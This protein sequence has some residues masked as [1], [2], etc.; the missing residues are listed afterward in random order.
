MRIPYVTLALILA[1]NLA[2][3]LY[4][5]RCLRTRCRHKAWSVLQLVTASLLNLGIVSLFFIPVQSASDTSLV[6]LMWTIFGYITI[7][8]PKYVFTVFDLLASLP[9]LWHKRRVA[10]LSMTGG[11]M[12]V[13]LFVVLWWGALINRY[14]ID[15]KEVEVRIPNLPEAFEGMRIVQISDLHVGTYRNDS[16]FLGKLVASINELHPDMIVFTGDI[17]N[18]RTAELEPFVDVLS[19]LHAPYGVFSVLG[20]H[21]YGD[22][23]KWPEKAA[24]EANNNRLAELNGRMGWTLLNNDYRDIVVDGDTL[25]IIGVENIGDPPFHVYGDLSKAYPDVTDSKTKILLSHNPSHWVMNIADHDDKE[26]ALTLSGH[27][28]AMQMTFFGWSPA[29]FRY[30][31]W[32]GLY[33]DQSGKHQLYVNIGTGTVGFPARIGATPEVTLITLDGSGKK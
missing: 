2:G 6:S 33:A 5:W 25:V 26:V 7:Y 12:A 17:V 22:Y 30:K 3:D 31:T 10:A 23:Y 9:R 11:V 29:S 1:L 20:N 14:N 18:R 19:G 13:V 32:G 8:V 24:R 21:D 28:H 4:I 16:T 27:T 15:V